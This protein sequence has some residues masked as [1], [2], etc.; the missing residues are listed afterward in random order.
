MEIHD[1]TAQKN[2][3]AE[4]NLENNINQDD[5]ATATTT[6]MLLLNYYAH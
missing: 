4:L 3:E 5:A 2:G 1:G 6:V